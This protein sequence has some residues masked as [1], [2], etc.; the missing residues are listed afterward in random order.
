MQKSIKPQYVLDLETAYGEPSQEGFGSAIFFKKVKT[1]D[2]LEQMAQEQ[3]QYFVG[4]KW[5]EWGPETWLA[6]WKEAYRR[7]GDAQPDIGAELS[8][9]EDFD[10][11]MQ[12]DMILNK[13][14]DVD[15]A[16]EAL[17]AA[18]DSAEVAELVAYNIGDGEALGGLV[19]AGRRQ[20]GDT[21][22]LVFLMD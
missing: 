1:A 13:I 16:R 18:Y 7:P 9:V 19:I 20:N 15:Q 14:E 12:V 11:Q 21:T 17:S 22:F 2:L 6:P 3:Y 10:T 8:A 4:D 5:Q